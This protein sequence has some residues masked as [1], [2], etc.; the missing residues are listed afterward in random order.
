MKLSGYYEPERSLQHIWKCCGAPL[1]KPQAIIQLLSCGYTRIC[2]YLHLLIHE[3][4]SKDPTASLLKRH[5]QQATVISCDLV[6][7]GYSLRYRQ[8]HTRARSLAFLCSS[9]TFQSSLNAAHEPLSE[10]HEIKGVT[11][12]ELDW[13]HAFSKASLRH[14]V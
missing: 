14:A 4:P 10:A 12:S 2:L 13:Q 6:A 9:Q 11:T 3:G 5:P 8:K 1:A 7:P